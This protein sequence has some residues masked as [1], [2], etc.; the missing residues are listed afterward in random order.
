MD[1]T[2]FQCGP[3]APIFPLQNRYL[4][5]Q[6]V[7][8]KLGLSLNTLAAPPPPKKNASAELRGMSRNDVA[9]ST[10]TRFALN[11]GAPTYDVAM[12][13]RGEQHAGWSAF[14]QSALTGTDA[15]IHMDRV[16]PKSQG[17]FAGDK[18]H[19]SVAPQHV[20]AAF[21]A[22]AKILQAEDS[23]VDKWKVTDMSRMHANMSPEQQRVTLGAQFTIYAKPD[24]PD[25][26][27]S[28]QYMGKLR[29]M[30]KSVENELRHAGVAPSSNRPTSDVSS[31]HWQFASYR[32]ERNS[33][34][35]GSPTRNQGLE[36][37]PFFQLVAF[38]DASPTSANSMRSHSSLLPAPWNRG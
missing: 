19:L 36:H 7:R 25:H 20:E 8:P 23:P 27:Y 13:G 17:D 35:V 31:Q 9:A 34:R 11:H 38:P 37:E 24:R 28:P 29:G 30:I 12:R 26:T 3:S 18:I 14:N 2:V 6:R 33:E 32:N 22:I 10:Q 15:F 16:S 4:V 1:A 5:M 21:N